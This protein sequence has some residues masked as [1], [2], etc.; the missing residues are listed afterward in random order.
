VLGINKPRL[1]PCL[2]ALEKTNKQ[3]KKNLAF[4]LNM[5]AFSVADQSQKEEQ[6]EKQTEQCVCH[7]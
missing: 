2:Q 7:G 5:F 1:C 4:T 6:A 3:R